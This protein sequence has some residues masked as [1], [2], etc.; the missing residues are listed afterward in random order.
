MNESQAARH[1]A[2]VSRRLTRRGAVLGGAVSAVAITLG[3]APAAR[4]T[5]APDVKWFDDFIGHRLDPLYQTSRNPVTGGTPISVPLSNG[6]GG[7]WVLGCGPS[8]AEN[9][10]I[11]IGGAA[12][13]DAV[14]ARHFAP[15]KNAAFEA[16]IF[17]NTA[18][19]VSLTVGLTGYNDP[20]RVLAALF[21]GGHPNGWVLQARN[22][23]NGAVNVASRFIHT[24]GAPFTIRVASYWAATPY[25]VL[26]INGNDVA[27]AEGACITPDPMCFEFQIWNKETSP[28]RWSS[29]SLYIDYLE[30]TQNR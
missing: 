14:D 3:R 23:P 13:A 30:V 25:A 12:P 29:P 4:A 19:A 10:R 20:D 5:T 7:I 16:R 6:S 27:R 15:I 18:Q 22:L 9:T 11:R 21:N 8:R 24:P 17:V 1:D 26:A 28:G 2:A